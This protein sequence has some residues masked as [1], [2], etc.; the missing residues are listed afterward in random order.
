MTP[1][2]ALQRLTTREP[3]LDQLEVSIAALRSVILAEGL[4]MAPASVPAPA[5]SSLQTAS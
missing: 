1:A 5:L 4:E 3:T 2:M